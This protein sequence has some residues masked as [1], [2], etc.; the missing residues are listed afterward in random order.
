MEWG[1]KWCLDDEF[2][3]GIP[4]LVQVNIS[5]SCGLGMLGDLGVCLSHVEFSFAFISLSLFS[6]DVSLSSLWMVVS[7]NRE[8]PLS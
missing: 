7:H 6:Y 8:I 2:L 3:E 5:F 1:E 4:C